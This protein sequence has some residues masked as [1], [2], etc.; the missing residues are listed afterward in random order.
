MNILFA[1][2]EALPFVA[3]GGLADV[4]QSLPKSLTLK[5]HDIRVVLP[6]YKII[7]D[8]WETGL[9]Y[10]TN[11][12]VTLSWR[13]IYC[14]VFY[15]EY[16]GVKYYFLDNEYYFKRNGVYGDFD[17]CERFAFFSKA[18]VD[19]MQTVDFFPDVLHA[20]D[21]QTA[22]SIPYLKKIY[23]NDLRYANIKALFTIHNVMYQG[24]Y[25]KEV[26]ED[27]LGLPSE[28][29]S[30]L[31]L[32]GDV[33]LMKGAIQT[34]DF[35]TT[36]SKSYR[37]ELLRGEN[38]YRMEIP[39]SNRVDRFTGIT[40]GID[41]KEYRTEKKKIEAKSELQREVNLKECELPVIAIVSRL[42]E[43]KGMSILKPALENLFK[44]IDFQLVML[45]TG[46]YMDEEFFKYLERIYPDR[47]RAIIRF[48][49]ELSKRIYAGSDILLM[50]SKTEPCGIA[51][52]IACSYGTIP[53]V[54]ETGGLRDTV[55]CYD[56]NNQEATNGFSFYDYSPSV[57]E[58][59][60]I[61]T[62]ELFYNKHEWDN[63]VTRAK[64]TDFS[65]KK[66]A[67]KYIE[68]YN[69]L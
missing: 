62:V 44:R 54:R 50:P 36:V 49:K 69:S 4:S 63:L 29:K 19:F 56:P 67:E 14:G 5:G 28:C 6:Y 18:I 23:Y 64:L 51:Q 12:T 13:R 20:N 65:W 33:N 38:S 25:G 39:L 9:T 2:S 55:K 58:D 47:V 3:S 37:D 46:E 53:I 8:K 17:D 7:K 57:L 41:Y 10:I 11:F 61:R 32:D 16:D 34:A 1:T 59:T 27:V 52:M 60:V 22:L 45:G 30:D 26:Y 68:V 21:W 48:D 35:V 31:L 42:C 40:N 66:S 43:Q 15:V 24:R